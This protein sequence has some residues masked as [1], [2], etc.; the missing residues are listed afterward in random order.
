MSTG[1]DAWGRRCPRGVT[2]RSALAI[3]A[4]AL[5]GTACS[6]V[7]QRPTVRVAE[8]R[9]AS[10]DLRGGTLAV[11]LQIDNPN[12][13]SLEG[14][15]FSYR[16]SFLDASPADTSAGGEDAWV[17]LADGHLSE[18]TSVPAHGTGTVTVNVPFDFSS[19]GLAAG[20]LLR[21]G[22][23]EYR[24]SGDLL[25][26]TPLGGKRLPFDERGRFRP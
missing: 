4:M 12:R 26:H 2:P 9:L 11:T 23:L 14:Q 15:D 19:V 3:V 10:M 20:R 25:F 7:F 16:L 8:V 21:Q 5:T 17:R 24:F 22:E 1:W 6:L 13:F 18:P